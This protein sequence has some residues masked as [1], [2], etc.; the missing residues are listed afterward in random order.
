MSFLFKT[1]R[2]PTRF[3]YKIIISFSFYFT[4]FSRKL[5]GNEVGQFG[6]RIETNKVT[7]KNGLFGMFKK[8]SLKRSNFTA[9]CGDWLEGKRNVTRMRMWKYSSTYWMGRENWERSRIQEQILNW[10]GSSNDD[11]QEHPDTCNQWDA[12]STCVWNKKL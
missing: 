7:R 3:F 10:S 2:V 4:F 12:E 5:K 9:T 1:L 11:R 8:K 6:G